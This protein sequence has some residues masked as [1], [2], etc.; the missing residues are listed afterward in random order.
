MN[1]II[2]WIVVAALFIIAGVALWADRKYNMG[3]RRQ[4]WEKIK[5]VIFSRLKGLLKVGLLCVFLVAVV[6]GLFQGAGA[7]ASILLWVVLGL[8]VLFAINKHERANEASQ[9]RIGEL[10]DRVRHLEPQE[11]E[12]DR[13]GRM[14]RGRGKLHD[15]FRR[16][17]AEKEE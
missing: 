16:Q 10:E 1:E 15:E 13:I 9:Y 4:R 8:A 5:S 17:Q 7:A 3:E 2:E 12:S 6:I 11:T 14:E